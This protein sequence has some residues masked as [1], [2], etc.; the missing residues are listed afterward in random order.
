VRLQSDQKGIWDRARGAG[1][2]EIFEFGLD[3]DSGGNH[4]RVIE[5][6][7][8]GVGLHAER[9]AGERHTEGG[10]KLLRPRQSLADV[11]PGGAEADLIVRTP[12]PEAAI[13]DAGPDESLNG[14]VADWSCT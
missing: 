11:V 8:L 4:D 7:D 9:A 3:Q 14:V 5:L 13:E 1:S 10:L 2:D 6:Q 12:G